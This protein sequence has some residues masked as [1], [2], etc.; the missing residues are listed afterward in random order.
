MP[1]YRRVRAAI[2]TALPALAPTQ[3]DN[4]ALL[5]SAILA[6]RT[7]CLTELARAIP[8]P[9]RRRVPA[10]KHDL[11][12]RLKRLWRFT[13]NRRSTRSRSRPRSSATPSP[14][15]AAHDGWR[16]RSTGRCSTPSCPAAGAPKA[17]GSATRCCASR[18]P[19]A[20]APCPCWRSPTTATTSPPTT[21]KTSSRS[22]HWPRSLQPCP[23][24]SA[25]SSSPTV[26]LPAPPCWN[27]CK[28]VGSTLWSASTGGPASPSR[29]GAAGSSATSNWPAGSSPSHPGCATGATTADPV[30]W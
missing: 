19:A 7:L 11:A 29:T 8:T 26:A 16:W 9:S 27:G 12:H 10:P 15:S 4:L 18:C 2:D 14:G 28:P 22:R 23:K 24:G 13:A 1:W 20:A 21:A 3:A 6:K 30:T 17:A 25:R 5:V